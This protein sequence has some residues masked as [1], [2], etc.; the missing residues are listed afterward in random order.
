LFESAV[1][2]IGGNSLIRAGE[3]GTI[4]EQIANARRIS[5]SIAALASTGL[6]MVLTHGNGPQ[7]GAQLLRSERAAG[8]AY[9]QG[10]DVCVAATQ[11]E[12]GYLLQQSLQQELERAGILQP[13][14]TVLTQVVVR[15]DD[16]AFQKPTKPIGPFY[17]RSAAEE[18]TRMFGWD[19]IEDAAR[20]YRRVVASPAPLEIIE[21]EVIRRSIN[22]GMLT[23]ATGGGGIPVVRENGVIR[24]VDAVIDKD[25]ASALLAM[26]LSVDL[27][28][29]ATDADHIYLKYRQ[30]GQCALKRVGIRELQNY[31]EAGEFPPG[32]MGPKVEAAILFLEAGGKEAIV[33][34]LEHLAEAVTADAGTHIVPEIEK[35]RS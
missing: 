24:G 19:M 14:T 27:L 10:L 8:Q 7:V 21:E 13:V 33:T 22:Q 30:P 18:K 28:V 9:E 16:P 11:G 32:S 15:G 4:A 25:H 17:S 1:I 6:H 35:V 34:S 20:G 26:K 23:I 31:Q 5:R 3:K 12:I 2:A 29:F